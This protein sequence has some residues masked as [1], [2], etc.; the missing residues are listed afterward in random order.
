MCSNTVPVPYQDLRAPSSCPTEC[1]WAVSRNSLRAIISSSKSRVTPSYGQRALDSPLSLETS[2]TSCRKTR[3]QASAWIAVASTQVPSP[4]ACSSHQPQSLREYVTVPDESTWRKSLQTS[5]SMHQ[6]R[7]L[8]VI[9]QPSPG[10]DWAASCP[11]LR[12][13]E[14]IPWFA[15]IHPHLTRSCDCWWPTTMFLGHI[16]SSQST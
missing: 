5:T 3:W 11:T 14:M 15:L 10:A 2:G 9:A 12:S 1:I 8:C 13:S 16:L 4:T 7:S 6:W